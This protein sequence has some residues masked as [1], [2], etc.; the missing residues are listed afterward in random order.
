MSVSASF[1]GLGLAMTGSRYNPA[2]SELQTKKRGRRHRVPF[3]GCDILGP[4]PHHVRG[5]EQVGDCGHL[6][7]GDDLPIRG[8]GHGSTRDPRIV[9][10]LR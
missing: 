7:F 6:S 9:M 1:L 5:Q 8:C 4:D 2:A 3:V 10:G